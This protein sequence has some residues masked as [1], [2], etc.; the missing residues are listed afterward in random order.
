MNTK[1]TQKKQMKNESLFP[2]C[3]LNINSLYG[4]HDFQLKV[5]LYQIAHEM[6]KIAKH[7]HLF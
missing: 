4:N 6:G 2:E 3:A 7:S 1:E 5:E